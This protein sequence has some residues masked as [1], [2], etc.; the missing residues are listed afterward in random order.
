MQILCCVEQVICKYFP[1]SFPSF[2]F[3]Y[4]AKVLNCADGDI[5]KLLPISISMH[6][7]STYCILISIR[8]WTL[9][10][11]WDLV[12]EEP[13]DE[14][15]ALPRGEAASGVDPEPWEGLRASSG[16]VSPTLLSSKPVQ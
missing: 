8:H 10:D 12:S 11:Q 2:F 6:L 1:F 9:E 15:T 7:L 4:K 16:S 14:L 3:F 13:A 5:F